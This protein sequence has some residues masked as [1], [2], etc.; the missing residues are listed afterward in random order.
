MRVVLQRV[1]R[2]S[3]TADGATLSEIGP[4]LLAFV[5]I[6]RGD[7][8]G[9][10]E[11]LAEKVAGLRVFED[12]DGKTNRSLADV[13]GEVLVVSQFTLYGDVRKGRRPSWTDAE[14]P[15]E[16]ARQVERF[17]E[18]LESAGVRVGR[19]SFGAHMAVEL[20]NDGPMTLILDTATLFR[21]AE[22]R[23]G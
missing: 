23:E 22:I 3:V 20:V 16:A 4:G 5:G 9:H 12:D 7:P 11:R 15:V 14:D 13:G 17:A 10:A 2:A 6:G 8:P 1:T 21:D 19:G 18:T